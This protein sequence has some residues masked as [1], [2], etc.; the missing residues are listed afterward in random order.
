M[1]ALRNQVTLFGVCAFFGATILLAGGS[2]L[3][4]C[5]KPP[6]LTPQ[7]IEGKHLYQVRCAHCHDEND[8]ALKQIPPDLHGVYRSSI[9]PSGAPATDAD[10]RR[11]VLSGKGM[12]PS[13]AGRFSEAQMS[14]LLAYLHT[15][16]R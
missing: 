3:A 14:A 11:V 13:F 4:G 5:H 1:I 10:V 9:L 16:L 2:A 7:E 6:Q 12:M 8:L 15:G